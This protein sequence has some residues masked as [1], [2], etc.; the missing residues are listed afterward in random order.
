MN[1]DITEQGDDMEGASKRG[2]LRAG[3]ILFFLP[4]I[5]LLLVLVSCSTRS[6][7]IYTER[8]EV[9]SITDYEK[10]AQK[11][12]DEDRFGNAIDVYTAILRHYPFNDEAVMWATYEIGYCYYR[13]K[14]YDR[15]EVYFRAVLNEYQDPAARSLAQQMLDKIGEQ[16]SKGKRPDGRSGEEE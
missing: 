11:E 12:Y 6:P 3:T 10:M 2:L 9:R 1:N 8:G 16:E 15:A 13:L 4:L 14:E 5:V 7:A